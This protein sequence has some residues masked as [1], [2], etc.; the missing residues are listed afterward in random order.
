M[1]SCRTELDLVITKPTTFSALRNKIRFI[2]ARISSFHWLPNFG[3]AFNEAFNWLSIKT[4]FLFKHERFL[5]FFFSQSRTISKNITA[6]SC[7]KCIPTLKI[8]REGLGGQKKDGWNTKEKKLRKKILL[9]TK[10]LQC[11]MFIKKVSY[12]N[13]NR[14]KRRNKE[15]FFKAKPENYNLIT[16]KKVFLLLPWRDHKMLL[17]CFSF[18]SCVE[19]ANIEASKGK[20]S[21]MEKFLNEL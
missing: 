2:C 20:H 17:F 12:K 13:E 15:N 19:S 3:R 14:R 9:N 16:S 8:G 4:F 21:R 1:Q 6:V 10:L 18:F 11:N 7:V 5:C